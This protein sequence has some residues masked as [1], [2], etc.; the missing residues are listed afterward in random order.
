MKITTKDIIK[1]LPFDESFKS[2]VLESWDDLSSDQKF[3]I[4]QLLWDAYGEIYHARFEK[5]MTVAMVDVTEGKAKMDKDFYKRVKEQTNRDMQ[6][7]A[8]ETV[9]S[10]DLSETRAALQDILD[11]SKQAN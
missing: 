7:Q 10:M 5:N 3:T 4:G 6:Q 1:L 9:P 11:T 2:S 8:D